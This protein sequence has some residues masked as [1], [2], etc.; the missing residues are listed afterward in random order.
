MNSPSPAKTFTPI[1]APVNN[2]PKCVFL[3]LCCD[4]SE[5]ETS[6]LKLT[7]NF[8]EEWVS[9]FGGR[10]CI[11]VRAGELQF[12]LRN[13][14]MPLGSRRFVHDLEAKLI[15]D[16]VVQEGEKQKSGM[17][18]SDVSK[19]S[20]SGGGR[21]AGGS[22]GA[23]SSTKKHSELERSTSSETKLK[24]TLTR[25]RAK[26]TDSNPAWAFESCVGEQILRGAFVN[27]PLGILKLYE[28]PAQIEACFVASLRDMFVVRAEGFWSEGTSMNKIAVLKRLVLM[29]GV[30][31]RLRPYMSYSKVMERF[32]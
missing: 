9:L 10:I 15:A 27:E 2:F 6:T 7:I 22:M 14:T 8:D 31:S 3:T 19:L 1:G 25:V 12:T 11:G 16:R 32:P 21:E 28:S 13:A 17:E 26:G 18:K 5:S 30:S 24:V 4:A 23:E 20:V 29:R